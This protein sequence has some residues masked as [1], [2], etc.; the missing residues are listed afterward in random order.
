MHLADMITLGL[1]TK[2][3]KAI[4]HSSLANLQQMQRKRAQQRTERLYHDSSLLAVT[5]PSLSRF[6]AP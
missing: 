1:S 5:T 4:T 6:Y 3:K 2:S